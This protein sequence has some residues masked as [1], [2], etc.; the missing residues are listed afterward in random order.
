[1][2]RPFE[3]DGAPAPSGGRLGRS[4][5]AGALAEIE[6]LLA[7]ADA[8]RSVTSE[9]VVSVCAGYGLDSPR[10]IP[11]DRARLYR[12]YLEHCFED[13]EL[14]DDEAA[15]LE[16][17]RDLLHLEPREIARVQEA[18]AKDVYGAAVSDVLDDLRLDPE[19]ESFLRRLRADLALPDR[20]ADRIF[21][22]RKFEAR[23][24][25][26]TRAT[27]RDTQL[28]ERREAAGEFVGRSETGFE[29][30]L[31]DAMA[32]AAVVVPGLH[33]FEVVEIAGYVEEG[34]TKSWHVT[35]R[36]GIKQGSGT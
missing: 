2:A 27:S 12:R 24:K 33:W 21:E 23:D 7:Q 15:D 25:A 6:A 1:M 3:A 35:V 36:A 31:A 5:K 32:K 8:V 26:I 20:E 19:E 14:S 10:R 17:L 28:V 30:A 4:R 22:T 34:L 9:A 11:R 13:G 16:H 18:V 29:A